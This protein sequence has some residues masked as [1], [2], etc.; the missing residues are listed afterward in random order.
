M[1]FSNRSLVACVCL[2]AAIFAVAV[3]PAS[4]QVQNVILTGTVMDPQGAAVANAEV[5]ATNTATNVS[6]TAKTNAEGA[7][8][9]TELPV[10]NYKITVSATGFK[11][12]IKGDVYLSAG[13]IQRADITLT[14]GQQA[15]T[16]MVEAGAV[17][18]QTDDSRLTSNIDASQ[19]SSMPLNGRNVFDLMQLAPGA[20]NADGVSFENGH[21]TV[22]NGLRPNFN[23]FLINGSSDK[24]LSGGITT[25]PNA[26]I[27][28]EFQELTLNM[29][30]QYGNSAGG[31][32]NVVTKSGGNDI[33]GSAYEFV[34]NDKFDAN[35]FFRKSSGDPT[36]ADKPSKLRFNQFG[37][38]LTGPIMKDK[39]FFTA[40]FQGE[41]F[42]TAAVPS[43]ITSESPEWRQAVIA[44]LPNSTAAL[45]Y[46]NFP[47]TSPGNPSG[48][49]AVDLTTYVGGA[50]KFASLMCPDNYPI[51]FGQIAA[52][53]QA[54]FGVLAS[55]DFSTAGPSGAACSV[56]PS[57]QAGSVTN[58][59]MPFLNDNVVVFGS[60]VQ[61]NLFNGNEWSGRVDWVHKNDRVFGEYYWLHSS[62]G[63]GPFNASSSI[64]GFTNPVKTASPN[65]QLSWVHTIS[66]NWVNEAKAGYSLG[67]VDITVANPGVPAIGFDD[68]SAGFGS[69][70]GYPQTFHENIYTYGDM[71]SFQKGKHAL[72]VGVDFRR[73]IENS[74]F[75]VARPSYYFFDQLYFAADAPYGMAAGVDPGFVSSQ[76]AQLSSNVRHWRNLEMGAF[77][78]DDWKVSRKL[79]LNLGIRYDLYTRH[80]EKMGKVT[81]FLPGPGCQYPAN[82]YCADWVLNANIPSGNPGCDTPEQMAKNV[83]AGVCGPGGFAVANSLGAGNHKNFG[84]RAGFAYDPWGNGKTA[85]RGGFGLSYEGTLY[86]P[87]SNS[88]WNPPYYSFNGVANALGG[89]VNAVVYGPT[90]YAGNVA[91]CAPAIFDLGGNVIGGT[92]CTPSGV[93]PTYTGAGANPGIGTGSQSV[94]NIQGYNSWNSNFANLT[95]IVWPSGLRDPLVLN[96]YFGFQREIMAKTTIEVNYVGTQGRHLFRAE[97][98]NRLPGNRL[99]AGTQVTDAF[100]RVLT[101]FGHRYLNPNYGRLRVWENVS[102]S[103]YSGLQASVKHQ[104]SH[105]LAANFNYTWSHSIDT[106]SD[107]HSGATS[108]NGAAAG[109]GYSLDPTMPMLDKG[110]STFDV[111]HRVTLN[112]IYEIPYGKDQKGLMHK[113]LGGW[114]WN[115]L[116][117]FQTGAHFTP[118]CGRNANRCDFNYDGER[119]DRPDVLVG[120]TYNPSR[121]QW[122]NGWF[123]GSGMSAWCGTIDGS[124]NAVPGACSAAT[125]FFQTP[126]VGCDGNLGRNTFTGPGQWS[127]DESLLKNLKLTE[128]FN[129]QFRFEVFNAMNRANFKLPSSSTGANYANRINSGN[130]GQSAGTFSPRLMQFGL[131][132]LW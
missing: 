66:P 128:R 58:R 40:S 22:V 36:L 1:I 31:V 99:G 93:A 47:T 129:V 85:I 35:D 26:D 14:I 27:V 41:R 10:G 2:L 28:Q 82:G 39:L 110:N 34:R 90:A 21:N 15:E 131:K 50:S 117:S 3:V 71:M 92:N 54:L 80:T 6:T 76:P 78:Q 64:H 49:N 55:D 67:R 98:A 18:V 38:T 79:T 113:V 126:C 118:Y 102:K 45:I 101:G 20:V 68:G 7:Y 106:G 115:G 108:A 17:T 33:H 16:V 19:V 73:N 111:R 8:R 95:G 125:S 4:A 132:L 44:G 30:A 74:E 52:K 24:G 116:W 124:G 105:G 87:L 77:F 13:S 100:G 53:F 5:V 57:L 91:D 112:Y 122:A 119:N 29:S 69:Y 51:G 59:T 56:T 94:G 23:G 83:L 120:N 63:F 88:R 81:T 9:I 62:D 32:V 37:G 89:D 109:D 123:A 86:N 75:N 72:K 84:P 12:A 104:M 96:Y 11:K 103:W 42:N 114:Q 61:G 121:D 97:Q 60:Q 107:W 46:Q 127:T 48:P 70:N 130:F 65:M 25:V 43:P